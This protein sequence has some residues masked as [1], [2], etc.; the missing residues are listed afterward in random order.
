MLIV[1]NLDRLGRNAMDIRK[2]MEQLGA[3]DIRVH[4]LALG[5]VDLTCPAGKMAM[6]VSSASLMSVPIIEVVFFAIIPTLCLPL[7]T[8]TLTDSAKATGK[9]FLP[10]QTF[11]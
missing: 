2:T 6:Q 8:L 9:R 10:R 7:F 3:S 11:Y 5:G 4:C 1:T